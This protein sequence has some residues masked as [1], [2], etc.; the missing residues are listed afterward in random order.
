MM[1][2]TGSP[3]AGS[4]SSTRW[5]AVEPSAGR[6]R[7]RPIAV[8]PKTRG[9]PIGSAIVSPPIRGTASIGG[10]LQPNASAPVIAAGGAVNAA[11]LAPLA[12]LLDQNRDGSIVDEH[13]SVAVG[14]NA[15]VHRAP[16][17]LAMH[18]L[19]ER[20][21]VYF[22]EVIAARDARSAAVDLANRLLKQ[23]QQGQGAGAGQDPLGRQ[24]PPQLAQR[25]GG[26]EGDVS[27][28]R[29][30]LF[31]PF[32]RLGAESQV[33]GGVIQGLGYALFEERLLE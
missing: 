24:Q 13:G 8:I 3:T 25:R 26:R 27:G 22:N 20:A 6:A 30:S 28:M 16:G 5:A 11:S 12:P 21:Q 17:E 14:G 9:A 18:A 29:A 19:G 2:R 32:N 7:T 31:E 15:L 23:M 1:A 10:S 4:T 33:E